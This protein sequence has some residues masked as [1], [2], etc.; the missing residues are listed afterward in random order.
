M[1]RNAPRTRNGIVKWKEF[2][3]QWNDHPLCD[4]NQVYRKL[5]FHLEA[6]FEKFKHSVEAPEKYD[7][8]LKDFTRLVRYGNGTDEMDPVVGIPLPSLPSAQLPVPELSHDNF[9][10]LENATT[11]LP[12]QEASNDFLAPNLVNSS[13]APMAALPHAQD[14]PQPERRKEVRPRQKKT[15]K[16]CYLLDCKGGTGG[17]SKCKSCS[18]CKE[19]HVEG[20]CVGNTEAYNAREKEYKIQ[21]SLADKERKKQRKTK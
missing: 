19:A 14:A 7:K 21:V 10:S 3:N 9:V 2:S 8:V 1:I 11:A 15:C 20:E 6:Y 13:M 17:Y 5:D 16:K 4:G 18:I 12:L